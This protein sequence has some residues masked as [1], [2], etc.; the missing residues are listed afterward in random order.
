MLD[1]NM[2]FIPQEDTARILG[3]DLEDLS[4]FEEQYQKAAITF[5]DKTPNIFDKSVHLFKGKKEKQEINEELVSRIVK[6][7]LV[8][9][10][11]E[12]YGREYE[13]FIFS[14]EDLPFLTPDD[15]KDIEPSVRPDL[16]GNYMKKDCNKDIYP[17]V[18]SM[19]DR[20]RKTKD[21]TAYEI[22]R[23]GLDISDLDPILYEM[24]GMNPNSIGYWLPFLYEALQKQEFF[25]IPETTIIKVP[26]TLLQLTRLDYESLTPATLRIVDEYCQKVFRL[27][28][29]K[30][31]FVKTGT[32]SSKFNFRNA[33]VKG[34]KEVMELG[35]YLLYIQYQATMLA[36]P[37][38]QPSIY[39]VSTTNEWCV[40]EYIKDKENNPCIYHGMPLHTEY[41]FFIDGDKKEVLGVM[42]YWDPETM[43]N[44]FA[45]CKDINET[46]DYAIFSAYEETLMH[47]YEENKEMVTREVKKLLQSLNLPGQWSLDIMQNGEDFYLIDM[48]LAVN[49]ALNDCCKD[50]LI[51]V[52]ENWIPQIS[53]RKKTS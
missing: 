35:E 18:L 25:K 36:G 43:K 49:S 3:V 41:R 15:L 23:Q 1:F 22:F 12:H 5:E 7:L 33:H 20:F 34:E 51:P 16:L 2:E 39:G 24:L 21:Q 30:E 28:P 9:T 45:K 11:V 8:Q 38:T 29:Q 19:Y 47:R 53:T 14:D 17:F 48:A 42:P 4:A 46:H 40:R 31:Y 26:I 13:Q 37:L 10:T 6:E 32:Y 27:N 50:K 44:R 52:E